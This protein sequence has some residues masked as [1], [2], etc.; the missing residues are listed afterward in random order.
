MIP[1]VAKL[2]RH[3]DA[4]GAGR[5]YL[6]LIESNLKSLTSSLSSSLAHEFQQLTAT[7]LEVVQLVMRGKS[8]KEIARTLSRSTS[9]IDFHR[10]NIRAKLG[11]QRNQNLRAYLHSIR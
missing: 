10:N 4:D 11:L 8:S 2:S 7:E 3:L 6:D 9:T 1:H 5:E